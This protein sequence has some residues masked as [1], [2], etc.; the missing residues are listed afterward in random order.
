MVDVFTQLAERLEKQGAAPM[1]A[2]YAN[3]ARSKDLMEAA[4]RVYTV[5]AI[6]TKSV[7]EAAEKAAEATQKGSR[8][9]AFDP[10][11]PFTLGWDGSKVAVPGPLKIPPWLRQTEQ[12]KV[13]QRQHDIRTFRTRDDAGN[14]YEVH[15]QGG[16]IMDGKTYEMIPSVRMFRADGTLCATTQFDMKGLPTTWYRM[17]P[18]GRLISWQVLA[19]TSDGG[20]EIDDI[21]KFDKDGNRTAW[22]IHRD[23]PGVI[24][25][26]E[27][28]DPVG[29]NSQVRHMYDAKAKARQAKEEGL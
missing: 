6:V 21:S 10:D 7:D 15:C 4:Q 8:P 22:S 28:R 17:D 5:A 9:P 25:L 27:S 14:V 13:W 23:M 18:A 2:D 20:V 19:R 26:E 29:E 16:A 1:K 11:I 12:F 24:W 3:L